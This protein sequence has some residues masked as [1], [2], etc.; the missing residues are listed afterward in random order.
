M[1]RAK[2]TKP[3][4]RRQLSVEK[5]VDAAIEVLRSHGEQALTMRRIADDC[6]VT[7][8]AVYHHVPDKETLEVLVAD[9]MFLEASREMPEIDPPWRP[10][11]VR[12]MTAVRNKLLEA[13]GAGAFTARRAIIGPG[14]ARTTETMFRLLHKGGLTGNAVA[15]AA[16]ALSV[17]TIGSVAYDLSRSPG[18]RDQLAD[19]LSPEDAVF[20]PQHM[21]HY[22]DRDPGDR[23][24]RA[25]NWILDGIEAQSGKQRARIKR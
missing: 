15:E 9:R 18:I 7:P 23:F 2:V 13:P 6:D 10:G 19:H 5:I 24:L 20:L 4:K 3:I 14:S 8:M 17:L 12:L 16:D 21:P 1:A 25:L 11:L 22:S